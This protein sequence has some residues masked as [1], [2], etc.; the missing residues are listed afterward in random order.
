MANFGLTATMELRWI[1][2]SG[3]RLPGFIL[4]LRT[5]WSRWRR[6]AAAKAA[7][8]CGWRRRKGRNLLVRVGKRLPAGFGTKEP[9][10][11][12][13]L[14]FAEPR[15]VAALTDDG[16]GDGARRLERRPEVE[17]EGARGESASGNGGERERWRPKE[18]KEGALYIAMGAQG[19]SPRR[20]EKLG[21]V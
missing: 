2:A 1:S 16:R 19:S 17:R 20:R 7:A 21:K 5:Q 10:A 3:N 8:S 9:K 4:L 11:R 14:D 18:E 6:K 15:E 12:V 13:E